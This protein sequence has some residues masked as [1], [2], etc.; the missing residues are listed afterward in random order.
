MIIDEEET[1]LNEG[2][3]IARRIYEY[4]TLDD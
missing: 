3:L 4:E 2:Q 1:I